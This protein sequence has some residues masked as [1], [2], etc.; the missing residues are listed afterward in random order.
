MTRKKEYN[1]LLP[2]GQDPKTLTTPEVQAWL[3]HDL[4]NTEL[5]RSILRAEIEAV[6]AGAPRETR[7]LRGV[8]YEIVKP[9]LSRSGVLNNVTS[10]NKPIAWDGELSEQLKDIVSMGLTSYE[11]LKIIDGS[12]QRQKAQ[13]IAAQLIDVEMVGDHF[14][15][16]ILFTEKDTIWPVV[17]SLANLYGVSAISG[18]G[19]PSNACSENIIRSIIR[20]KAYQETHYK[21]I[22]L[23]SL[24]DY[25]PA[26]YTIA[27]AQET[28]LTE[29]VNSMDPQERGNLLY[30]DHIR[31]GLT[32]DQLTQAEIEANAYEPKNKGLDNWFA[33]T[34]G[35]NGRPLG[36]ELDSLPLS[37]LRAM[38][39]GEIEKHI[40]LSKR[41]DDLREAFVDLMACYQLLPGFEERR[42]ELM[43]QAKASGVWQ[44]IK[45]VPLP[46]NLFSQAAIRGADWI[47]Q[48]ET[49]RLF[50]DYRDQLI[51][52]WYGDQ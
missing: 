14:P 18:G 52:L 32:P 24:T 51:D 25:D 40:D 11:D 30:T 20:T 41:Y 26:G 12:R 6:K 3:T 16:L 50:S 36:L 42:V 33:E 23:L 49:L 43:D 13:A 4:A 15:W 21:T 7:T 2:V 29:A 19:Q 1:P 8:W 47:G 10:N 9:L 34:G 48:K 44:A 22:I 27:N 17:Q 37:K 39:A 46:T 5:M 35:I 28:Q 31:I 45:V 38:F